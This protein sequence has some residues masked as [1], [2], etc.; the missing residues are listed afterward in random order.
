MTTDNKPRAVDKLIAAL[1]AADRDDEA[2]VVQ[3]MRPDITTSHVSASCR[4]HAPGA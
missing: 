3:E 1:K 4:K 2:V